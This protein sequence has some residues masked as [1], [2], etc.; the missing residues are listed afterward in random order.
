MVFGTGATVAEPARVVNQQLFLPPSVHT[1]T[2]G[3]YLSTL[4]YYGCTA[5]QHSAYPCGPL[6]IRKTAPRINTYI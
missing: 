5:S 6:Q 4:K 1:K 2:Q 3:E